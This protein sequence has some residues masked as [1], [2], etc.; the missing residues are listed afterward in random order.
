MD[1]YE[2]LKKKIGCEYISD[3]RYEPYNTKAKEWM[4]D[5]DIERLSVSELNDIAEYLYGKEL[6]SQEEAVSFLKKGSVGNSGCP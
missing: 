3:L 4:K 1:I 6:D 2:V 5:L